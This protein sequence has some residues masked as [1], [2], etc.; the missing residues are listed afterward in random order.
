MGKEK[1][2]NIIEGALFL[3]ADAPKYEKLENAVYH[4]GV[5]PDLG[6]YLSKVNEMFSFDYK[7]YGLET[8]FINRVMKYYESTQDSNLGILLNGL[9]GTGKTVTSK[10]IASKVNQPVIIIDTPYRGL[11]HFLNSIPQDITIFADEYEKVFK[12][13]HKS[14]MLTIMDGAITS[15]YR[16]FFLLTTNYLKV[17][18][19][20]LERPSRVRYLKKFSDLPLDII[21]EIVDDCLTERQFREDTILFISTLKKI[22]IDIVKSIITEVNIQ[23]ESPFD[24]A[25]TF[26]VEVNDSKVKVYLIENDEEVLI[27][28][29]ERM[30]YRDIEFTSDHIGNS[31]Y[32]GN[33]YLGRINDVIANDI[34][35]ISN[36]TNHDNVEKIL[37]IRIA[38]SYSTHVSYDAVGK[39][40]KRYADKEF[41]KKLFGEPKKKGELSGDMPIASS[42]SSNKWSVMES[43]CD[44]V[45]EGG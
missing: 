14:D 16:R 34:L 29:N 13:E 7:I 1:Q 6:F 18:E 45:C 20:L 27:F 32:I 23:C 19:N 8:K 17:D 36:D 31:F 21:T 11:N 43:D 33:T 10:I 15:P 40:N 42:L 4:V 28:N 2:W 22:T 35:E 38:R 9:K 26:N 24:F 30:E 39:N 3:R 25:D 5:H 12:D 37:K 44:D 41:L